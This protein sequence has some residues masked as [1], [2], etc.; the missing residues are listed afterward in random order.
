MR[1]R[2]H[3][4]YLPTVLVICVASCFGSCQPPDVTIPVDFSFQ[5]P[6]L[7]IDWIYRSLDPNVSFQGKTFMPDTLSTDGG[8]LSA[9]FC[10]AGNLTS[11][12]LNFLF[13][14]RQLSTATR[15]ISTD[16]VMSRI[17]FLLQP[18]PDWLIVR[19]ATWNV[20]A[21]GVPLITVSIYNPASA[22][23]METGPSVHLLLTTGPSACFGEADH[24]EI[25]VNVSIHNN[26]PVVISKDE[27]FPEPVKRS[28]TIRSNGCDMYADLEL[29]K[30]DNIK[31]DTSLTVRFRLSGKKLIYKTTGGAKLDLYSMPDVPGRV[32]LFDGGRTLPRCINLDRHVRLEALGFRSC[33]P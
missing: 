24:Q 6:Q 32:L 33:S 1:F 4:L 26:A 14:Q 18:P 9:T 13:G 3:L 2:Q 15:P 17:L 31:G 20:S 28:S 27:S 7:Q 11:G 19:S 30:T 29:G 22:S 25:P 21:D 12:T 5:D 8:K 10:V 16:G 23:T